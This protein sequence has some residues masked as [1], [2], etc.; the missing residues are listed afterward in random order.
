MSC[1]SSNVHTSYLP[2]SEHAAPNSSLLQKQQQQL[3][4]VSQ[5]L[6]ADLSSP[7]ILLELFDDTPVTILLWESL[8]LLTKQ[9]VLCEMGNSISCRAAQSSAMLKFLA[10]MH[11]AN[12]IFYEADQQHLRPPTMLSVDHRCG[13]RT[14][15]GRGRK[16]VAKRNRKGDAESSWSQLPGF[17]RM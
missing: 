3:S 13:W 7:P 2:A 10:A 16:S 11:S 14:V 15:S 17:Q 1:D 8:R 9:I 12:E 6:P 5:I 4:V